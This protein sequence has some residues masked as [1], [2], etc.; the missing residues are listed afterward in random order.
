MQVGNSQT[1]SYLNKDSIDTKINVYNDVEYN[2][3]TINSDSLKTSP[4]SSTKKNY[5]SSNLDIEI[6]DKDGFDNF[7]KADI[8]AK[9]TGEIKLTKDFM[10]TQLANALKD[11]KDKKFNPPTFDEK[12]NHFIISG[13]AKKAVLNLIDVDFEIRLGEKNGN[14]CFLVDNFITRGSIYSDLKK[15]LL[16]SGINT[17]EKDNTLFIQ[18]TLGKT[19]DIPISKDKNQTG[20]IEWIDTNLDNT[21]VKI[22][23]NGNLTVKVN[24][25]DIIASTDINKVNK[26][27]DKPDVAKVKFDF[28]VDNDMKLKG[29]FS[30]GSIV[31]NLREDTVNKLSNNSELIRE[32]LGKALTLSLTHL[33]GNVDLTNC[34]D[35]KVKGDVKVSS[36]DNNTQID[37]KLNANI[38][39]K[40]MNIKS[41]Y[42][43][44]KLKGNQKIIAENILFNDNGQ[45]TK[46]ISLNLI[47]SN[48]SLNTVNINAKGNAFI[49]NTKEKTDINFD[50][51]VNA[52]ASKDNINGSIQTKGKHIIKIGNNSIDINVDYAKVLGRFDSLVKKNDKIDS[53]NTSKETN[54]NNKIQDINVNIKNID[55]DVEINTEPTKIKNNITGGSTKININ[56]QNIK[57]NTT[58]TI[59]AN[60]EGKM[61]NAKAIIKGGE[62]NIEDGNVNI[63][64]E[65]IQAEGSYTNKEGK[66]NVSG[67]VAG[68]THVNIDKEGN[69]KINQYGSFNAKFNSNNKIKVD[70]KGQKASVKVSKNEDIDID[71]NNFKAKT[72]IKADNVLVKTDSK[73]EKINVKVTQEGK[74]ISVKS[75]NTKSNASVNLKTG[76]FSGSGKAG[77]VD[78]RVNVS[79]KG[80]DVKIGVKQVDFKAKVKNKE[81]NLNVDI[82]TKADANIHVSRNGSVKV[83]SKN[84]SITTANFTLKEKST[85]NEKIK[86]S[87]TGKDFEVTVT[88]GKIQD[89]NVK[90]KSADFNSTITPNDDIKTNIKS[91]NKSDLSVRVVE[92]PTS[93]KVNVKSS[94]PLNGN[95]IVKNNVQSDFNNKNGFTVNVNEDSN[96]TKVDVKVDVLNLNGN[97]SLDKNYISVNGTGDLKVSV[98]DRKNEK[99]K[100]DVEYN[101]HNITGKI[102][103]NDLAQVNYNINGNLKVNVDGEKVSV[104]NVGKFNSDIK[105]PKHGISTNISLEGTE[106]EPI[107]INVDNEVDVKISHP[108]YVELKD[109]KSLNLGQDQ[110]KTINDILQNLISNDIKIFTKNIEVRN[111]AEF[112]STNLKTST[113][114]TQMGRVDLSMDLIKSN[115]TV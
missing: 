51:D 14:L 21:K 77:D 78:I 109:I 88:E 48:V 104:N 55:A 49:K 83:S 87:A 57:V 65:D 43:N 12:R 61:V 41:D 23:K 10:L 67:N 93:T 13:T 79:D 107:S 29:K 6:K 44:G 110:N 113:I 75:K 33:T 70:G 4:I 94:T 96:S 5:I 46:R 69:V 32:N 115:S 18:P 108:G 89:I 9:L 40:I 62:V 45:G 92:E 74:D 25:V 73:G 71:L 54:N 66:L 58:A 42:L 20:R 27:V 59:N 28:S 64:S 68:K 30:D 37:T 19:I 103:A 1:V 24:N 8:R 95:I 97:V 106:K 35:L 86:T 112:V 82:T 84:A 91:G 111:N 63:K 80:D 38:N 17:F 101:N 72:D 11:D 99:T 56:G 105:S 15:M 100:V 7:G 2:S 31:V 98:N 76:V 52:S 50:G 22:D 26:T 114:R 53:L 90:L 60:A 39:D 81:D 36:E 16:E 3:N 85:N 102:S 47:E 34:L